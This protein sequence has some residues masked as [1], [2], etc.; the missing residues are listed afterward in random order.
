MVKT[1]STL[2]PP[3]PKTTKQIL[4]LASRVR[5]NY[6]CG[7]LPTAGFIKTQ[8]VFELDKYFDYW[9]DFYTNNRTRRHGG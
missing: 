8:V 2:Q 6:R 3:T 9:K 7:D 1:T 4:A 5:T